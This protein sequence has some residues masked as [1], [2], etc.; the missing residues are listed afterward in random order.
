MGVI[1]ERQSVKFPPVHRQRCS[2]NPTFYS[3]VFLRLNIFV[4]FFPLFFFWTSVPTLQSMFSY[5]FSGPIHQFSHSL[6]PFW[7]TASLLGFSLLLLAA[8][9]KVP[10][11]ITASGP[12]RVGCPFPFALPVRSNLYP[13][14]GSVDNNRSS[15]S[16][17]QATEL[18]GGCVP[19]PF[20][21]VLLHWLGVR[22]VGF[23]SPAFILG[24]SACTGSLF[25]SPSP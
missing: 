9:L 7:G 16:G 22:Q 13:L 19:P 4:H 5:K 6:P 18:I 17:P 3:W 23:S 10:R 1:G 11:G 24:P 14:Y 25:F 2:Y 20:F 12:S 21:V 8:P 15:R